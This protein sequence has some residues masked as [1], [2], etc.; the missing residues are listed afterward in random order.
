[1]AYSSAGLRC[2]CGGGPIPGSKVT[3]Q[4]AGQTKKATAGADGKWIVH[5]AAMP[6]SKEPEMLTVTSE[7]W[8][9]CDGE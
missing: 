8:E 9:Q 2:R 3:V 1:M 6:V 4:F 5:L 7:G